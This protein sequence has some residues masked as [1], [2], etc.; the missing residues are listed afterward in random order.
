LVDFQIKVS[1]IRKAI[2]LAPDDLDPVVH[3]FDFAGVN[4]VR[5]VVE[6]AISVPLQR[7]GE[8]GHRRAFQ[9]PCQGA[10]IVEG[11]DPS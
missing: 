4:G 2:R 5:A 9:G 8:A 3:P 6:N 1:L 10:P 11:E 7:L